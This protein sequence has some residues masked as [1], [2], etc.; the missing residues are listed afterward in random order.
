MAKDKKKAFEDE[1]RALAE[2][3]KTMTQEER[4]AWDEEVHKIFIWFNRGG[5]RQ[6]WHGWHGWCVGGMSGMGKANS[7]LAARVP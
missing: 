6:R 2:R 4:K 1:K 5:Q 7:R 3:L